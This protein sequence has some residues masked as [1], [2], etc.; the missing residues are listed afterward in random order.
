M[1]ITI[2]KK[3]LYREIVDYIPTAQQQQYRWRGRFVVYFVLG[4]GY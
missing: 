4:M 2:T 1:G 3:V